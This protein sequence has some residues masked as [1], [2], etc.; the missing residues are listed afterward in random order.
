[1]CGDEV[2]GKWTGGLYRG[3]GALE[4]GLLLES[5]TLLLY[6]IMYA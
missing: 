6:H 2:N 1:M 5:Y 3:A 4:K